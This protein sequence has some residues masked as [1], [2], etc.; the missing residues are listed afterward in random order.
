MKKITYLYLVT[1]VVLACSENR[2]QTDLRSKQLPWTALPEEVEKDQFTFAIVGDLN[3]GE[4]KRV[5]EIAA[6][7]ISLL[8]PQ[9]TLSIG[10]L[11]DGGSEDT[12]VLK[13]QFDD[14]DSRVA[15]MGVPFFH[16]GGNHDIT[17]T[18]MREYW[19]KRY[20]ARYYHFIFNNV[21][22]LMIDSEDYDEK[23]MMEIFY[24][25]KRAIELLDSGKTELAHQGEYFRMPERMTGNV[26]SRQSEYFVNVI[27][28]NPN[29]RWTFLFMHKPLWKRTGEGS[30]EKIESALKGRNYTLFNGH[31]HEYAYT[32]RNDRDYIMMGTTGG[33]QN[34]A[35][36]NAFDHITVV[37]MSNDRPSI[38]NL[39]LDGMLDK[40][41]SIPLSGD[42][43]CFQASRCGDSNASGH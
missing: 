37:T 34:P 28:Q 35:L 38:L 41:G 11:I 5:F 31:L 40:S 1:L 20:G 43:I 18:V 17:N 15:K 8:K 32:K 10:D 27:E 12:T 24:A 33:G 26:S 4:R 29:V 16:L 14:F 9:F 7:Q 3:G 25:R 13:T 2:F 19:E 36:K 22:F 42:T 21:L 6:Q 23:R 39:R 30:L